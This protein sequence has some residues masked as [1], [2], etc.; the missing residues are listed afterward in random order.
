[1]K[2]VFC[3]QTWNE[4]WLGLDC[5]IKKPAKGNLTLTILAEKLEFLKTRRLKI[6]WNCYLKLKSKW[7]KHKRS[8]A[9]LL[10]SLVNDHYFLQSHLKLVIKLVPK[11][12]CRIKQ[13]LT[14]YETENLLSLHTTMLN[15]KL[16]V[17]NPV[18]LLLF[19]G[20]PN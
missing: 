8:T 14:G 13:S 18:F 3:L 7:R 1:M 5:T 11:H 9:R 20:V 16:S 2:R 12:Y 6:I 4:I 15:L 17:T 10:G 19:E